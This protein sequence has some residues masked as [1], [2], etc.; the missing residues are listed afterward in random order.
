[1]G[2]EVEGDF[3][4][5]FPLSRRGLEAM[6][7]ALDGNGGGDMRLPLRP[8]E[9]LRDIEYGR[10]AGFVPIA[11]FLI[12]GA[13]A[14]K[15]SG[16]GASRFNRLP[17]ERLIVLELNDEMGVRGSGGLEGFFGNASHRK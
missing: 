6:D 5:S 12:D 1:M 9:R 2:R 11:L 10:G 15:R 17:Q 7:A 13:A 14:G 8:G 3:G 16:H 4:G